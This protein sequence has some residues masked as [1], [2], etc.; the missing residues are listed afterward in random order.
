MNSWS[1]HVHSE[2]SI[3]VFDVECEFERGLDIEIFES[4]EF[5]VSI[6]RQFGGL[7]IQL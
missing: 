5:E 7:R 3:C 4:S 1:F 2:D 6:L